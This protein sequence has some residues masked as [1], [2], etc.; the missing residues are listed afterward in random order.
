MLCNKNGIQVELPLYEEKKQYSAETILN[1]KTRVYED[2]AYSVSLDGEYA[3]VSVYLN[4]VELQ[5]FPEGK[6]IALFSSENRDQIFWGMIG[7]AQ[8]SFC[9]SY[10]DGTEEWGYS[11]YLAVMVASSRKNQAIDDMLGYIY[12]NQSEFLLRSVSITKAKEMGSRS[13]I[14][15]FASQIAVLQEIAGIYE[16]CF[17]YFKVNSRC[18]LDVEYIVDRTDRL[19]TVG[20]PTIQY[21]IQ[22]PEH[23]KQSPVGVRVGKQVFLPDKTLTTR[24][25][26]TRDIYENRVIIGFLKRVLDETVLLE[27]K[28]MNYVHQITIE[29]GDEDG[30]MLSAII[31][32][33]NARKVLEGY[34][35]DISNLR[36]KIERLHLS[37]NRI[38]PIAADNLVM[39]PR[40]TAIFLSVPQYNKVYT[41]IIRWFG[42][43]GYDL[44][45]ER[46]LLNLYSAPEIYEIYVLLRL[47]NSFKAKGFS[48]SKAYNMRYP[49]ESH[50]NMKNKEY[51]NTFCLEKEGCEVTV[52]YEPVIYDEPRPLLNGIS[53]YRNNTVSFTEDTDEER[54]GHFY[55]PDYLIK[56]VKDG[57]TAY[58]ICDAK[59]SN[60]DKVRSGLMPGLAYKYLYSISPSDDAGLISMNVFYALA[61]NRVSPTNFYD[62]EKGRKIFPVTNLVPI[63]SEMS[64]W[65]MVRCIEKSFEDLL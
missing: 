9:F 45:N 48:I 44:E 64:E 2:V 34:C 57:T 56:V 40:P 62:K 39:I 41:S 8:L 13:S 14:G 30:Y 33:N 53:L 1:T 3:S 35:T 49:L 6:S 37:Y 31:L 16:N 10:S 42:R 11:D 24:N 23:L 54:A 29:K 55:T 22:H 58:S 51:N 18:K 27:R 12:K 32:Y 63:S 25:R 19:Q 4:G 43:T 59:F 47:V 38:F 61:D 50:W 7:F 21:M 52:Y 60:R 65:E 5:T 17:G 46:S 15:D 36:S 26:I 20:A 28:I